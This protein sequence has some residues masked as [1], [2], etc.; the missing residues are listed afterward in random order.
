[1]AVGKEPLTTSD[2]REG[3]LSWNAPARQIAFPPATRH[4][5]I[6]APVVKSSNLLLRAGHSVIGGMPT[7]TAERQHEVSVIAA[8]P[9]DLR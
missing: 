8:D 3:S 7:G 4:A 1:M 2:R 9:G 6:G 5:E